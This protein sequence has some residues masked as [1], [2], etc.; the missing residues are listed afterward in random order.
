MP[1]IVTVLPCSETL[2]VAAHSTQSVLLTAASCST[3]RLANASMSATACAATG[4][5]LTPRALHTVTP[6]SLRR[7][8]SRRSTP[9]C[10]CDISRRRGAASIASL[11]ICQP[12]IT[13]ASGA[14]PTT[15]SGSASSGPKSGER[16]TVRNSQSSGR[17]ARIRGRP[18]GASCQARRI[19]VIAHRSPGRGPAQASGWVEMNARARS[20]SISGARTST[21]AASSCRRTNTTSSM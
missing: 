2:S 10:G 19:F 6:L 14:S 1:T 8:K 13:S 7:S 21:P 12:I 15:S 5:A 17:P 9:A 4:T 16:P 11:G 18:F 3:N 20:R